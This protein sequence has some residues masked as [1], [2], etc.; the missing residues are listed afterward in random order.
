MKDNKLLLAARMV[1]S[2]TAYEIGQIKYRLDGDT[3]KVWNA[4]ENDKCFHS[5]ELIVMFIH[6]FNTL[7]AYD[8]KLNKCVL[9]IF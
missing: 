3:L 1:K 5:C 9:W 8:D 2:T 7:V 6:P 4:L